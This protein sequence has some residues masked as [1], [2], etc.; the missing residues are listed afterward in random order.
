[1]VR[2]HGINMSTADEVEAA[3]RANALDRTIFKE[4][5]WWHAKPWCGCDPLAV[6]GVEC[7]M[8]PIFGEVSEELAMWPLTSALWWPQD[9]W[10]PGVRMQYACYAE[11]N[12]PHVLRE[13]NGP[14]HYCETL[15][16]VVSALDEPC[17]YTDDCYPDFGY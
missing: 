1:M 5:P 7:V 15:H 3:W 14:E 9:P 13:V 8:S 17:A 4:I 10:G 2:W 11:R 16:E 6:H 12:R